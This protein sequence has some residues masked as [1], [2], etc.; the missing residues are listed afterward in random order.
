M[1]WEYKLEDYKVFCYP[2]L[3]DTFHWLTISQNTFI[4]MFC[5]NTYRRF[6]LFKQSPTYE[7]LSNIFSPFII[8]KTQNT[9][10]HIPFFKNETIWIPSTKHYLLQTLTYI[11]QV[12]EINK[13]IGLKKRKRADFPLMPCRLLICELFPAHIWHAACTSAWILVSQIAMKKAS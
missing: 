9:I 1:Y 7:S 10:N 6:L 4:S 13:Q 2:L 11:Y 8:F 12:W 5:G 3:C